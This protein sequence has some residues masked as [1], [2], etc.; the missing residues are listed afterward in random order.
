M[1]PKLI[2]SNLIDCIP[3]AG[4]CPNKCDPCYYNDDEL[5]AKINFTIPIMPTLEEVGDK[6]VRVN[7]GADSS[8]RFDEVV[9]RT[10]KYDKKYYN[11]SLPHYI[12]D[13]PAPVVFTCNPKQDEGWFYAVTDPK[14]LMAVRIRVA[15]WNIAGVDKAVAYYANLSTPVI[16]T[17]LYFDNKE[18]IQHPEMYEL[19]KHIENNRYII[20]PSVWKRIVNRYPFYNVMTCGDGVSH[21]CADCG[22]CEALYKRAV[23]IFYEKEV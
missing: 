14:N 4:P 1:N 9:K 5:R 23:S 6:I 19:H 21:L 12:K 17:F 2:G 18:S 3:T 11:T 10:K 7:S 20:K 13:F 8:I 15:T 16:L 22:N